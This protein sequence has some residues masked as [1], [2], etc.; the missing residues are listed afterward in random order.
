MKTNAGKRTVESFLKDL[1]N[2]AVFKQGGA[3]MKEIYLVHT[4]IKPVFF[5]LDFLKESPQAAYLAH[6]EFARRV[7]REV[8]GFGISPYI[9]LLSDGKIHVSIDPPGFVISGTVTDDLAQV[10][11]ARMRLDEFIEQAVEGNAEMPSS[12]KPSTIVE[13]SP[14]ELY[15]DVMRRLGQNYAISRVIVD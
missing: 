9:A 6:N 14:E 5:D 10:G 8:S 13:F 1:E 2:P 15:P 3:K 7:R 11:T 4:Q 12:A